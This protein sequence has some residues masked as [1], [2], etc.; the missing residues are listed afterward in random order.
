[1]KRAVFL[2]RDGVINELV[3]HR[4][5]EV[6]DSPFTAGQFKLKEGAATGI[7]Q[8]RASGYLAVVVSNQPGVAKRHMTL[9]VFRDICRKMTRELLKEKTQL[10]GEYYCLHHP[11]ARL[12]KYRIT[13]QCRKPKPGLLLQAEKD[14]DIDLKQSW[15][16][17]D[18]LS[19]IAAGRLAGCRTILITKMKCEI[20][21]LMAER[22]IKPDYVAE[23]IPAALKILAQ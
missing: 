10:D 4:E 3:Y 9:A 16:I 21:D 12:K 1:M 8:I 18:N 15:L 19:D 17:G 11:E 22:Q 2:D 20:C 7:R 5:Q 13:C 14:L 6:I 23:N